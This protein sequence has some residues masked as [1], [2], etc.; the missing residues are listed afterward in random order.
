MRRFGRWGRGGNDRPSIDAAHWLGRLREAGVVSARS[1]EPLALEALAGWQVAVGAGETEDG[2]PLVVAFAPRAGSD[3]VLAALAAGASRAAAGAFQNGVAIAVAPVW[4]TG[5]RRRLALAAP[6]SFAW[7][8]RSAP[9]LADG[10]EHGPDPEPVEG[11]PVLAPDQVAAQIEDPALRELF[12]RASAGLSG[13]A[14]KHDGALRG[15]GAQLELVLLAQRVAALRVD[16]DAVVLETLQ[17]VRAADRLTDAS[18]ADAL[19]RLEGQLRKRL[20]DRGVREG[21][22]GLR[23]RSLR[24]VAASAGL[25][26][27]A[28]WPL[29]GGDGEAL[30]LVGLDASGRPVAVA[31][32]RAL[33]LAG[34]G[35]ILD[36][37]YSLRAA[38]PVLLADA[39]PPARVETPRLLL[40]TEACD[41]AVLQV[42][43]ETALEVE[44]L[45]LATPGRAPE[46]LSEGRPLP[47]ERRDGG[48]RRRRGRRSRFERDERGERGERDERERARGPEGPRRF[49]PF[50]EAPEGEPE[51]EL[52]EELEA[53][54]PAFEERAQPAPREREGR[55][56]EPGRPRFEELSAFDLVEEGGGGRGE[57]RRGRRGRRRRR[58]G[59]EGRGPRPAAAEEGGEGAEPEP[60]E[61]EALVSGYGV[62][63]AIEEGMPPI[64]AEEP[65]LEE[66]AAAAAPRYDDEEETEGEPE[67]DAERQRRERDA[68]R[69]ARIAKAQPEPVKP[70]EPERPRRA[71]IVAHADRAS[72]A[73][74]LLLARD[75]RV[76]EGLWVYPQ[77]ELM[78]FFR[79]VATDLREDVPIFVIGF[80]ARPAREVIQTASLYRGRLHWLDHHVWPPEDLD[81]LRQMLGADVVEVRPGLDTPLPMVLAR[82]SRRSRFSDKLVDL[83]TGRFSEHDFAR[84]G[85]LWWA[86]IGSLVERQGDRRSDIEALLVGRPSDLA[87]EAGRYESPPP[88]PELA[89]AV[90][91]DFALTHFGGYTLVQVAVPAELDLHLAAR[92]ARER[93]AAPLSLAWS[94]GCEAVILGGEGAGGRELDLLAMAEH[95]ANKLEW[96][97]LL[98][99][100]DHVARIRVRDLAARPE[101]I[102]EVVAEIAM[103][104]SILEG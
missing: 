61:G 91:R 13:L 43:R 87:R 103:G 19:D 57:E 78:T 39:S 79:S 84:W 104:R 47:G 12:R 6:R 30:D 9:M 69:R 51:G 44:Q 90:E 93:Y 75:V 60:E 95:L 16:G 65:E 102:D 15:A 5:A 64:V 48:R 33:G 10:G 54:A 71:A 82:S 63:E 22:E 67:S 21:E 37:A 42:I 98:P 35:S 25:R 74:A 92:I 59:R 2:R 24:S 97:E 80:T 32:R 62:A 34:L 3:A 99:G 101:R 94:E 49:E 18:L 86:R 55:P 68:R 40:A 85:R 56:Q 31:I 72:V 76:L 28:I 27:L 20:N 52:P 26:V 50:D 66:T 11:R 46:R 70:A 53:E 77:S 38:L 83:V 45:A 4:G 73:A 88:P 17:P 41:D 8:V 81:A 7:E 89:W 36:A 96:A 23:A 14:A 100:D 58:G 29:P 1:L